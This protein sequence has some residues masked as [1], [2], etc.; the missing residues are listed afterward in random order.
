[1]RVPLRPASLLVLATY[2]ALSAVP[3]LPL[4][5]GRGVPHPGRIMVLELLAWALIWALCLRPARFHWLLLP[6]FLALPADLYLQ[7]FYGEPISAHHL[8]ILAETSPAEAIEFLGS[9]VWLLLAA[10][11]GAIGWWWLA[12]I[13]ARR[14]RQL[15]WSGRSRRYALL[16]LALAGGTWLYG[17][18][19]GMPV[20]AQAAG[21][22]SNADASA[23]THEPQRY[24][25]GLA[26]ELGK[27]P[28]W[29]A[30]SLDAAS[31]AATWPFGL[32]APLYDFW[33]EHRYLETLAARSAGFSFHAHQAGQAARPQVVVMVLGESSR[34]D[35]WGLNGYAR[36]TTPRLARETNLVSLGDLVTSVS[37]TRLSVPVIM[38]RKPARQSLK[39]EFAEKS[40]LSAYREAG[41]KT[42]W[43][44][45]QMSFGKFDTPVSVYADEADVT[46]FLNPGDFKDSSS[47]DQVLLPALQ[48]ALHDPAPKK[49]IV[50]HTLGSHWNYSH[51]YPPSFDR[52]RPSLGG[53][54]DPAPTDLNIKTPM[55]NSYDN[56]ILYT[57][58]VLSQIIAQLAATQQLAAMM[59]VSDHGQALYDGSCRLAFHGHNTQYEFHVPALV[60]YSDAWREAY[61]AKLQQLQ[62][63]R[64]APLATE[65]VFHSLLDLADIHY[66]DERLEWSVFSSHW[67]PHP[68]YVDS[69]GW[70]NYD[71]SSF[72]GDC[73]E[74]IDKGTPLARQ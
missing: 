66:P 40:F 43:L 4:A 70:A 10:L 36:N 71:H 41:F 74:V 49:L 6:A 59:Y 67:R 21:P 68:R 29:A 53:A 31:F 47:Y 17:Q 50:L 38:S 35:R 9:H 37:A 22:G 18:E 27:L 30:A 1:M 65:N 46:R 14:T 55:N 20:T 39:A 48:R 26:Q 73:R 19:V 24:A 5:W 44:S 69:Y 42:W 34:Y 58:W 32:A 63:H 2:L 23:V 62:R 61:P 11:L 25:A 56:S 51:R 57:D 7:R 45:N 13:A 52:W 60:W 8:G 15:D 12:W 28:P 54:D 33:R 72:R 64:N 3:F 16:C